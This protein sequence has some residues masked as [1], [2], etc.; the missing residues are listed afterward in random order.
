[1]FTA[2]QIRLAE[3]VLDSCRR[4]KVKLGV[5]ESCTGGLIAACLTSVPGSSDVFA[6]GYITYDNVAKCTMLDVPKDLI[7]AHGAVSEPVVR[8]M[9]EGVLAQAPLQVSVAAS[10]I[11]GP[12]GGTVEKPVGLVHLAAA[13]TRQT[14]L[15]RAP[16]FAGDRDAVRSASVEAALELL[17]ETLS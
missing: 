5:A 12:G 2:T 16:V 10:G 3:Q 17:L 9:A 6:R 4:N 1:M 7:D 15:H 11:A 8:A 14:T 13:R